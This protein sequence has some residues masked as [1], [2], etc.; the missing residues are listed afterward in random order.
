M[1]TDFQ[2]VRSVLVSCRLMNL[3]MLLKFGPAAWKVHNASLEAH[4]SRCAAITLGMHDVIILKQSACQ[5]KPAD[6]SAIGAAR[7]DDVSLV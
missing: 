5:A 1:Y 6:R 2:L 3:E 4:N 7:F